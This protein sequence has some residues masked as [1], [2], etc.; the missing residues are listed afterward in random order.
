MD[1]MT[2]DAGPQQEIQKATPE[3]RSHQESHERGA[4][5]FGR[6]FLGL[7]LVIL[8]VAF[9]ADNLGLVR[10][11]VNFDLS[12]L[13]P[14]LVIFL[15]LSLLSGRGFVSFLIGIVVTVAVLALVGAMLFGNVSFGGS[16]AKLHSQDIAIK[17]VVSADSAVINVE[18]GAGTIKIAGDSDYLVDGSHESNFMQLDTKSRVDDGVQKVDMKGSQGWVRVGKYLNELDIKL[19]GDIPITLDI[20]TGAASLDLDLGDIKAR[21][22]SINTGASDIKVVLGDDL[23]DS[24]LSIDAGASS[25]DL[26]IPKTLGAK[27]VVDDALSSKQISGFTKL[28]E[29]H[30]ESDNYDWAKKRVDINLNLGVSSL[31]VRRR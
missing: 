7:L 6:L 24:E 15:G 14:L 27:I 1:E 5:N 9:L 16:K 10:I 17:K 31:N 23:K 3:Q 29:T 21:D 26:V 18:M 19:N 12:Q 28:D 25:V 20:D 22:V 2:P 4:F 11:S 8:G 30:Y 13:W